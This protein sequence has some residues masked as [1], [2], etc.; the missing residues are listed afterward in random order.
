MP[1]CWL[2]DATALR[3]FGR[4]TDDSLGDHHEDFLEREWLLAEGLDDDASLNESIEETGH[5][6][7]LAFE[8][9][10]DRVVE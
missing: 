6:V 3:L 2:A 7:I 4:S 1:D 9:G 8:L 5:V 10:G